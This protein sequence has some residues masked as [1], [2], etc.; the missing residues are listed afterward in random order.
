MESEL[1]Y[2]TH[3]RT[4]PHRP[5]TRA[6]GVGNGLFGALLGALS[7]TLILIKTI[8]SFLIKLAPDLDDQMVR[9][10]SDKVTVNGKYKMT[11][12]GSYFGSYTTK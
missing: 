2:A 1:G 9:F 3:H 7:R 11:V 12:N 4:V 8:D 10:D 5:H 6:R